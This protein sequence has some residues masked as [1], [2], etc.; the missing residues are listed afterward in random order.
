MYNI[1]RYASRGKNENRGNE[2]RTEEIGG[3]ITIGGNISATG[4]RLASEI[5]SWLLRRVGDVHTARNKPAGGPMEGAEHAETGKKRRKV[6]K[7]REYRHA[8]IVRHIDQFQD[9]SPRKFLLL[10]PNKCRYV[11]RGKIYLEL[12]YLAESAKVERPKKLGSI[13]LEPRAE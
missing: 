10:C 13:Q 5:Q 8:P 4:C 3:G 9:L 11:S 7:R 12:S 2:R 6:E 1:R